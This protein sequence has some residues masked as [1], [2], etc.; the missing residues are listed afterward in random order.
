MPNID[1]YKTSQA[2]N[3]IKSYFSKIDREEYIKRGEELLEKEIRRKK[4]TINEVLS[5]ERVEKVCQDLKLD[6]LEDIYLS[7]GSLR[8]TP[9]YIINMAYEDKKDVHDILIEKIGHKTENINYKSDIIV[10]GSGDIKVNIAKCCKPIKG[11]KIIGY[12][13]KGEGITVHKTDCPNVSN[14]ERLIEVSWNSTN[15]TY[16]FTDILISTINNKNYLYD[17]VSLAKEKDIY[18]DAVNSKEE[19]AMTKYKLTLKIKNIK[20]LDNLITALNM[21]SYVIKVERVK[22]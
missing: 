21:C 6:N 2:K 8:F 22:N 13:T 15:E 11:D 5:S 20:E 9:T 19:E 16:Y 1:T 14:T 4:L 17:I 7:V 12:I 18:I 10:A 3:K